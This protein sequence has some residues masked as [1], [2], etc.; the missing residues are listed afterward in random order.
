MLIEKVRWGAG[1]SFTKW[2]N[3]TSQNISGLTSS[4]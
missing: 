2:R 1:F 4:A 3:I